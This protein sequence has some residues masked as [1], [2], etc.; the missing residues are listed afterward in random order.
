M[1][2]LFKGFVF[3]AVYL[4]LAFLVS[5]LIAKLAGAESF[6]AVSLMV[7]NAALIQILS[8]LGT[9]SAILIQGVSA[10]QNEKDSIFSFTFYTT[11]L[12]LFLFT[13]I[14][15]GC[16]F[17]SGTTILSGAGSMKMFFTELI[18]FAGLVLT[19]KYSSLLYSKQK[20]AL[21]N[22]LL[23]LVLLI[24]V[25]ILFVFVFSAR[26]FIGNNPAAVMAAVT[27]VPAFVLVVAY[28]AGF[29]SVLQ[30][31]GKSGILAFTAIS[32]LALLTNLLQFV[33]Y[34]VDFWIID[35]YHGKEEVGV[36]AQAARFAQ[37][38]WIVP[39]ILAGLFIPALKHED[40]PMKPDTLLSFARILLFSNFFLGLLLVSGTYVLY[41][42]F[43]P[44][45][46][47]K[48][49]FPLLIMLPGYIFFTLTIILSAW[50]AANKLLRINLLASFACCV[51]MLAADLILIPR[52]SFTG[53]AFAN[54]MAYIVTTAI[55]ILLFKR[56]LKIGLKDFFVLKKSDW[57]LFVKKL[58]D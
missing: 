48:G 23:A 54:L 9:D 40:K 4:G 45:E 37:M 41:S 19:E 29:R 10:K 15:T 26:E 38:L 6:G 35:Y 36:Y 46:Y 22:R 28:H 32:G 50:F 2:T 3:R 5:L 56:K 47:M 53:A 43:L 51:L 1:K 17:Y 25:L 44:A 18:Y 7:V 34:R 20:A 57:S 58:N 12:Q 49:F 39:V 21:C 31:P 55:I 14:A 11:L 13:A 42:Y 33:A 52:Y 27:F 16:Y 24:L 8:G 30:K